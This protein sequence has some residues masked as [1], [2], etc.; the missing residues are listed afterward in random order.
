[1]I[2]RIHTKYGRLCLSHVVDRNCSIEIELSLQV[3][4]E[5]LNDS[6]LIG[7]CIY[8]VVI[9]S[10][11]GVGLGV[12]LENEPHLV[13]T[14]VDIFLLVGTTITQCVIFMP[15]VSSYMNTY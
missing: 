13:A 11:L 12:V 7:N 5:A 1:M 15:K 2:E 14:L 10:L 9:L 6:Q 8:N 3:K 4:L